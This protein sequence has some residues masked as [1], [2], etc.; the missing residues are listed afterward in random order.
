MGIFSG[1]IYSLQILYVKQNT[2]VILFLLPIWD[3]HFVKGIKKTKFINHIAY[4][5]YNQV[6]IAKGIT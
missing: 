2:E 5:D 4:D 3:R 6:C 1:H